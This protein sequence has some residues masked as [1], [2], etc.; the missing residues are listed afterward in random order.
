MTEL[1]DY[2]KISFPEYEP[3]PWETLFPESTEEAR[4]LLSKFLVYS[5]NN[6]IKAEEVIYIACSFIMLIFIYYAYIY[7]Y[8]CLY[9]FFN[10]KQT[11]NN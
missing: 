6:R 10:S 9:F 8:Y 3:V 11:N 7:I 1:P 4:N 2:N 5:A